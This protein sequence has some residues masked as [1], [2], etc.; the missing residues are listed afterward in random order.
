MKLNWKHG[1]PVAL[2]GVL[3]WYVLSDDTARSG[4]RDGV[5]NE[6]ANPRRTMKRHSGGNSSQLPQFSTTE[7]GL[8]SPKPISDMMLLAKSKGTTPTPAAPIHDQL[9][10]KRHAVAPPGNPAARERLSKAAI[11][12][13]Q[14][15][16]PEDVRRPAAAGIPAEAAR[17]ALNM[18][19]SP[20]R[21]I[22]LRMADEWLTALRHSELPPSE[23]AAALGALAVTTTIDRNRRDYVVQHLG[24]LHED[25]PGQRIPIE[26]ILFPLLE[27]DD[28]LLPGSALAALNAIFVRGELVA[29]RNLLSQACLRIFNQP[30]IRPG[31][32]AFALRMGLGLG[33]PA[34]LSRVRNLAADSATPPI[35]ATVARSFTVQ[36]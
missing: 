6:A 7:G 23:L 36:P 26:A 18:L 2:L 4:N 34:L 22:S 3:G 9:A 24:H 27:S 1:L 35:I 20:E 25:R 33:N 13:S 29:E 10:W 19:A 16:T 32:R 5:R 28:E 30:G 12:P 11:D 31:V 14:I 17:E 8:G 21:T 15:D